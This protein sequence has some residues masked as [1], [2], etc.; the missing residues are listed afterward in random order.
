MKSWAKLRKAFRDL[1]SLPSNVAG[2]ATELGASRGDHAATPDDIMKALS[3][4][5]LERTVAVIEREMPAAIIHRDHESFLADCLAKVSTVGAYCEFG[6]YSGA[7]INILAKLRPGQRFD[8]FDSFRGLPTDWSGYRFFDFNRQ[9]ATPK[10]RE[11]VQ[12]HVGLFGE[13]LPAYAQAV[14]SVAFLHVDC[15]LYASTVSIFEHL[16]PKLSRGS[17]I[18]FD[19]YFGYP[20]FELHERKAFAEFL[21]SSGLKIDW[22]ACCGQR[23]A[24]IVV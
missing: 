15:D 10:V 20:G 16:G 7:S 5:A 4:S 6:V 3:K 18:V 2:I 12:L 11:N 9:G 23:A 8:G 17:V 1:R 22:F 21:A 24:C 13:T 19:E 14:A